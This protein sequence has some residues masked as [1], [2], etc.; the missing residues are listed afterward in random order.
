MYNVYL[1][2]SFNF[3]VYPS[4]STRSKYKIHRSYLEPFS[5][6]FIFLNFH[7]I[8]QPLQGC[9]YHVQIDR[10]LINL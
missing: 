8:A 1:I 10:V 6:I 3:P 4:Y 9:R 7:F 2:N 5:L